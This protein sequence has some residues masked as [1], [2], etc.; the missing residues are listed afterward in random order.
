M[1]TFTSASVVRRLRTL[2]FLILYRRVNATNLRPDP[3]VRESNGWLA[4]LLDQLL[5]A[6]LPAYHDQLLHMLII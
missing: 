4:T 3:F 1:H 5:G 2:V 6:L